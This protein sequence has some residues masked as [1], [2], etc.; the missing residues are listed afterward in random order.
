MCQW[1]FLSYYL[2]CFVTFITNCIKKIR[3]KDVQSCVQK[4]SFSILP[5]DFPK[6]PILKAS[7]SIF[8]HRSAFRPL[9]RISTFVKRKLSCYFD[10]RSLAICPWNSEKTAKITFFRPFLPCISVKKQPFGP[11]KSWKWFCLLKA[12]IEGRGTHV[13]FN[14]TKIS[15]MSVS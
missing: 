2:I 4:P 10:A 6:V 3:E 13:L 8:A 7:K 9:D 5:H 15:P 14:L 1:P 11:F 12:I